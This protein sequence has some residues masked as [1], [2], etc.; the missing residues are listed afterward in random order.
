MN[1]SFHVMLSEA[2]GARSDSPGQS[3]HPCLNAFLCPCD[4]HLVN[5]PLRGISRRGRIHVD[6]KR[7]DAWRIAIPVAA[8]VRAMG[9]HILALRR[10]RKLPDLRK[11]DAALSRPRRTLW[12]RA[13]RGRRTRIIRDPVGDLAPRGMGANI[14]RGNHIA[15]VRGRHTRTINARAKSGSGDSVDPG[16]DVSLLLRQHAATLLLIEE[17]NGVRGKAFATRGGGRRARVRLAQPR[18]AGHGFQFSIEPSVEEH[19]KTEAR[20]LAGGAVT[21]PSVGAFT[22]RRGAPVCRVRKSLV[23]RLQIGVAGIGVAV[24]AEVGGARR[25]GRG[26]RGQERNAQHNRCEIFATH[27]NI[28]L[29]AEPGNRRLAPD[30]NHRPRRGYEIRFADVVPFFFLGHDALNK[31]L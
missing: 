18:G 1:A 23:K 19:E 13:T 2:G 5:S 6:G 21:G 3:K 26:G 30:V 24:E 8:V 31:F 15:V 4:S 25:L 17:D 12:K 11:G 7:G 9:R 22:G 28:L 16:V 20:G 10:L 29:D 27:G 14:F